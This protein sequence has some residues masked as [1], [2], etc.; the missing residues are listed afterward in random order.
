MALYYVTGS[1]YYDNRSGPNG[2]CYMTRSGLYTYVE[3]GRY[4]DTASPEDDVPAAWQP[5]LTGVAAADAEAYAALAQV[6]APFVGKQVP[7]CGY[8]SDVVP[9]RP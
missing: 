2:F 5:A 6:R 4:F 7:G 3:P 9:T 1:G 8:I